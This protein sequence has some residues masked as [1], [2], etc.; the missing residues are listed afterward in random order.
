MESGI[1]RFLEWEGLE[2][3]ELD[4]TNMASFSRTNTSQLDLKSICYK[5]LRRLVVSQELKENGGHYWNASVWG[6]GGSALEGGEHLQEEVCK[7]DT[8]G[9][10]VCPELY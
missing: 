5:T 3:W 7:A 4:L 6:A 8:C 1:K 2:I 10:V 9:E